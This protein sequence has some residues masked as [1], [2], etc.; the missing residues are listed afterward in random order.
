MRVIINL[1]IQ[2]KKKGTKP[3]FLDN[4]I[5]SFLIFAFILFT[6]LNSTLAQK[7][8]IEKADSLHIEL[9]KAKKDTNKVNILNSIAETIIRI[10][11]ELSRQFATDALNL[12]KEL[13]WEKGQALAIL[14]IGNTYWITGN[15]KKAKDYY[16]KSLEIFEKLDYKPGIATTFGNLGLVYADYGNDSIALNYYYK[17]LDLDKKLKNTKGIIRHY[18]NIGVLYS[19]KGKFKNALENYYESLKYTDEANDPMNKGIVLGNLG[20]IY[21]KMDNYDKAIYYY[22][23]AIEVNQKNNIPISL[24]YN[25]YNLA[26]LLQGKLKW[27]ESINMLNELLKLQNDISDRAMIIGAKTSLLNSF[28]RLDKYDKVNE[29]KQELFKEFNEDN[30]IDINFDLYNA[31]ANYYYFQVVQNRL[32]TKKSLLRN[33]DELNNDELFKII[34]KT[35]S[36]LEIKNLDS[37]LYYFTQTEKYIDSTKI[38]KTTADLYL[39]LSQLNQFFDKHEKALDYFVKYNKM[40][41]SIYSKENKV[42]ILNFESKLELELKDKQLKIKELEIEKAKSNQLFTIIALILAI[43]LLLTFVYLFK[44]NLKKTKLLEEQNKK[45][46]DINQTKDKLFAI[47]AHDLINPI[48]NFKNVTQVLHDSFKELNEADQLEYLSLMKDSSDGLLDM[49][50]NLLEWSRIQRGQIDVKL[51]DF[52]IINVINQNLSLF[53][54]SANNKSINLRTSI[55]DEHLNIIGDYNLFT[56]AVRNVISNAIKFTPEGGEIF[57][58]HDIINSENKKYLELKI[59]DSGVGISKDNLDKLFNLTSIKSTHGTNNEKGTGLGLL[60]CKEFM[61]L[62]NGKIRVESELGKGTTLILTI[63]VA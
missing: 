20:N 3:Y 13:K 16:N 49:L 26:L 7:N 28:A 31:F 36:K 44:A 51:D 48:S 15:S 57:I 37:S 53:K 27:E 12:T 5:F 33:I 21:N 34:E 25:Y 45:I 50:K 8:G 2:K 30:S 62:Q 54:I 58:S 29:I 32:K 55:T 39:K 47:I 19:N 10:N 1:S 52:A 11:P 6:S 63:P 14:R 17:A 61:E 59:K 35:Y 60:L 18:M 22:K 56:T 46:N 41:D 24:A 40:K 38:S 4:F 42:A 43:V 9:L 23:K